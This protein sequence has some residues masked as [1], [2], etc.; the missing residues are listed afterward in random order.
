MKCNKSSEITIRHRK[1][2]RVESCHNILY[3]MAAGNYSILYLKNDKRVT[4]EKCLKEF[5]NCLPIECFYRIRRNCIINLNF[6]EE[7]NCKTLTL[8][9]GII[10]KI[11]ERIPKTELMNKLRNIKKAK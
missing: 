2:F 11:A 8:E 10:L 7:Y 4:I 3:C 1:S 6:V 5:Q 9:N